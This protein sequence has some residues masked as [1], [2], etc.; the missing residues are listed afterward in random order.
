MLSVSERMMAGEE[1]ELK[2][3]FSSASGLVTILAA[4]KVVWADVQAKEDGFFRFGARYLHIS[5]ADEETLKAFLAM[6]AD[7]C[8]A[9]AGLESLPGGI[10]LPSK[11]T[12]PDRR[13]RP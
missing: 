8:Q 10:A 11:L 13:G 6:Y 3:Y 1:L 9:P 2:V 12:P 7:P 4:V 5:A